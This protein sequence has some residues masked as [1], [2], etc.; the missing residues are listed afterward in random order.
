M[1]LLFYNTSLVQNLYIYK[2][3]Y[4]NVIYFN[5]LLV[6]VKLKRR[7]SKWNCCILYWVTVL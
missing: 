4:L 3:C 5:Y 2:A 1:C 6:V 7:K